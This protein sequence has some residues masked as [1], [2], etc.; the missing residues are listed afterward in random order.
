MDYKKQLENIQLKLLENIIWF[1]KFC[2]QHNIKYFLNFGT[3]IG[4]LRHKDFIPW[5][6]DIDISMT[7]YNINKLYKLIDK[8]PKK[9]KLIAPLTKKNPLLIWK[10]EDTSTTIIEK[11]SE[12]AKWARGIFIDIFP[13]NKVP[14]KYNK[15]NFKIWNYILLLMHIRYKKITFKYITY[16]SNVNSFKKYLIITTYFFF[17]LFSHLIPINSMKKLFF[18]KLKKWDKLKDNYKYI[19]LPPAPIPKHFPEC[20]FDKT[21]I[22]DKL[23]L[24]N[25]KNIKLP[26]LTQSKQILINFYGK[27]VMEIPKKPLSISQHAIFVDIK[28][29]FT[30]YLIDKDGLIKLKKIIKNFYRR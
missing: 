24:T 7:P 14:L 15:F 8:F 5:D 12:K 2:T 27:S 23:I 16:N 19:S 30:K 18:K 1:D 3:L 26:I 6:D 9:Y 4:A 13:I 11:Y 17:Y 20:V 21:I 29:P 22:E 28:T 25:F 10:L